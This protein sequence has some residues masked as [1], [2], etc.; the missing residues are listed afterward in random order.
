MTRLIANWPAPK[1]VKAFTTQK[2]PGFSQ[3]SFAEN[4]LAMH[5]QDDPVAVQKNRELL[6]KT[7]A[8]PQMPIWLNQTHST[9]CIVVGH[10]SISHDADASVTRLHNTPLAILTADCLPIL[11][12]HHA[13]HEIAAIHAGWRGLAHGII[14][15]TLNT[16]QSAPNHYMAWIGPAICGQC[17]ETGQDVYQVFQHQYPYAKKAFF[18]QKKHL[19]LD[20]PQM[21]ELILKQSGVKSVSLSGVCTHEESNHYYSYRKAKQTGRIATIIWSES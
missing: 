20:L 7:Y 14:E 12:C 1:T 16:L 17:Y 3:A 11:L 18:E 8:L 9:D 10:K 2:Y 13:G 5:V 15:N 6:C 4:N 19:H 21:A